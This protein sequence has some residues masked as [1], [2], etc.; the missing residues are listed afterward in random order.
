MNCGRQVARKNN[1]CVRRYRGAD[2]NGTPQD[3]MLGFKGT[4]DT[5]HLRFSDSP[6]VMLPTPDDQAFWLSLMYAL[7]SGAS[8]ALQIERRD[9]AGVLQPRRIEDHWQ[10]TI[11]LY[12]NVPGGA[13]YVEHIRQHLTE[14]VR[15]A[16]KI[17]NCVNCAPESS[18]Y[19]CLRDY[20]N[21]IY[22]D[23][24]ER[25][26]VAR[27]LE[28]LLASLEESRP[29]GATPV[30]ALKP[31]RWL[32]QT[33]GEA[34]HQAWIAADA[35]TR[36]VPAGQ[37][38]SWIDVFYDL[39]LR[40]VDVQLCF[41]Q[42]PF[43]DRDQPESLS[44]ARHMQVLMEQGVGVHHIEAKPAWQIVLDP[45]HLERRALGIEGE[46]FVLNGEA[47]ETHILSNIRPEGVQQALEAF[48]ALPARSLGVEDFAPPAGV[49]VL[50]VTSADRGKGVAGLFGRVITDEPVRA[51]QIN[52]RY[53]VDY[54]R[55]YLR[56]RE[57]IELAA[58]G[59]LQELLVRTFRAEERGV[60]GSVREQDRA[61]QA[62]R[63]SYPNIDIQ[64]KFSKT[65]HDRS[66]LLE[67]YSGTRARI[68]LGRGLDFIRPDG[69]INPTYIIIEDPYI[70]EISH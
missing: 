39:R 13:G 6:Y 24:L 43:L 23:M 37:L 21:Q 46:A 15:E 41:T 67:R 2:C 36:E 47:G 11:V 29:D 5:L 42:P 45:N 7:V 19:Q 18:C 35:V 48:Y 70:H 59:G 32:L 69:S 44:L 66:V 12:D 57:Y 64:F 50:N 34:R 1:R 65:E 10:Q 52:D 14:V 51:M 60:G 68:L 17:A 28:A 33:V 31:S 20:D 3:L 62:L 55:A 38:R 53:L 54:E 26:R 27:Y 49:Y 25:G 56:L 4:T 61:I 16:L 9:I 30:I 58:E 22:H 40:G 63:Q 8:R